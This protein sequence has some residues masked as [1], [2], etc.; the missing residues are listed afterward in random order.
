MIEDDGLDDLFGGGPAGETAEPSY[1]GGMD[2]SEALRR[3]AY[4]ILEDGMFLFLEP[5]EL[6]DEALPVSYGMVVERAATCMRVGLSANAQVA[7]MLAGNML[8]IDESDVSDA[9]R[10]SA[11][12]EALNIVAGRLLA[13]VAPEH[14]EYTLHPP[15]PSE[16]LGADATALAFSVDGGTLVLWHAPCA[17]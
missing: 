17:E 9:D 2:P 1:S 14:E 16:P 10:A 13:H 5:T 11:V 8:G 4:E 7:T 15:V 6:P 12:A 3:T